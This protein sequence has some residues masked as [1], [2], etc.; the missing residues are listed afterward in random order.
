MIAAFVH[1]GG[2]AGGLVDVLVGGVVG[3]APW[4]VPSGGDFGRGEPNGRAGL[5]LGGCAAGAF[6][7]ADDCDCELAPVDRALGPDAAAG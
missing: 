5:E 3:L 2:L 1:C 6:A 4:V 7:G